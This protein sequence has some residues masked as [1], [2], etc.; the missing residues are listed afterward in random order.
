MVREIR[1][2]LARIYG[3]ENGAVRPAAFVTAVGGGGLAMGKLAF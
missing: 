3:Q 1:R 2:Q